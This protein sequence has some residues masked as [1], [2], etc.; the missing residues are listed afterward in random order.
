MWDKNLHMTVMSRENLKVFVGCVDIDPLLYKT[1]SGDFYESIVVII[2]IHSSVVAALLQVR[3]IV[4]L[5]S[6]PGTLGVMQECAL[7]GKP[8]YFRA[9]RT[10]SHTHSQC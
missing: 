9:S 7:N 10:H 8:V 2:F 6:I 1:L 3:V 5:R 4:K